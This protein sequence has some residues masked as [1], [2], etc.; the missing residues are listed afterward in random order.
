MRYL[1]IFAV[2]LA[3]TLFTSALLAQSR[4]PQPTGDRG[5]TAL[6]EADATTAS[7]KNND[8]DAQESRDEIDARLE[9]IKT[10]MVLKVINPDDARNAIK[11][12]AAEMGGYATH[13]NDSS[14]T[15]K[16]PPAKMADA[17]VDFA[18]QGIVVEKTIV[19]Q[20]LTLEIAQLEGKLSSQKE[21][22]TKLRE[23]FD[24]SDFAATL[25]IERSMSGLVREIESVKGRLRFLKEQS[26]W[27][28]VQIFFKFRERERV[29]YV[30]S[31]FDW[32]N[33]ANLNAF[34]EEF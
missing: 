13:L 28:V 27:A 22:L 18:R 14:I 29:L 33:S 11:K 21:I 32:L 10:T 24:D 19:R 4:E 23:F 8:A 25:D 31:P 16:I 2:N 17:L 9:S 7:K 3:V 34:L 26:Q 5:V 30:A 1:Q 6:A 15:L 12:M 20:D